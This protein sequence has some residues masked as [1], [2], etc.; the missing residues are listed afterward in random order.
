MVVKYVQEMVNLHPVLMVNVHQ[1]ATF[2]FP[3]ALEVIAS[4]MESGV[5]GLLGPLV[6]QTV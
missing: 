3:H 5:L 1:L 2:S 4:Q 6:E